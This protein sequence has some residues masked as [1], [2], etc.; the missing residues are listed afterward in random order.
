MALPNATSTVSSPPTAGTGFGWRVGT[1][2]ITF[3][4]LISFVLVY[5]AFWAN[6]FSGLQ[7][8]VVIIVSLLVFIGLNGAAWASWGARH[9]W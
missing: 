6:Q 2:I 3:F 4:G 1:S 8:A 7:S 5:L 9:R